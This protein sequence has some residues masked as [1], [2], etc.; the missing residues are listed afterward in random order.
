VSAALVVAW[1]AL[2]GAFAQTTV[3]DETVRALDG[4]HLI[5]NLSDAVASGHRLALDRLAT[6]GF[7]DQVDEMRS[8]GEF[9]QWSFSARAMLKSLYERAESVQSGEGDRFLAM[10]YRDAAR[11]SLAIAKDPVFAPLRQYPA[12]DLDP[13]RKPINFMPM[14][15]FINLNKHAPLSPLAE[16]AIS[17]VADVYAGPHIGRIRLFALRHLRNPQFSTTTFER[18][19][20]EAKGPR[21]AIRRMIQLGTPPPQPEKALL[22]ILKETASRTAILPS[23]VAQIMADLTEKLPPELE[24]YT[25]VEGDLES[26]KRQVVEAIVEDKRTRSDKKVLPS[27][28]HNTGGSDPMIPGGLSGGGGP[29]GGSLRGGAPGGS[30][31]LAKVYA[32]NYARYTG[33]TFMPRN[34]LYVT[35][36]GSTKPQSQSTDV[37]RTSRSFSKARFSA[38]A[39]RG[40]SVGATFDSKISGKP[41]AAYWIASEHDNR[42]GRLAVTIES[43]TGDSSVAVTRVMFAD[44]FYAALGVL[45]GQHDTEATF[46]DG[47]ILVL[48]SLDPDAD[49]PELKTLEKKAEVLSNRFEAHNTK[50]S[51]FQ[52]DVESFEVKRQEL[53]EYAEM[54]GLPEDWGEF[55][56]LDPKFQRMLMTVANESQRLERLNH[57]LEKSSL[58]LVREQFEL[59]TE[60]SVLPRGVVI[61]PSLFGRE[62]AW[63]AIR[64]DFSFNDLDLLREEA[65]LLNGNAQFPKQLQQLSVA[66]AL[67]WQFYER[68]AS[69]QLGDLLGSVRQLQVVSSGGTGQGSSRSHFAISLF[70][71]EETRLEKLEPKLQPLLDWLSINHHD[72]IR[73]GD[74]SESFSLLRWLKSEQTSITVIDPDGQSPAIPT[75]D[76]VV[77]GY[78]PELSSQ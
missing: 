4:T 34:P 49:V 23:E 29:A 36:T 18:A 24:H 46:Y 48:M 9:R 22:G 76:R 7:A 28:L 27:W 44:S 67:T 10:V 74:F 62:L 73:L 6:I 37:P 38:R 57:E 66:D 31:M 25:Q 63:S 17:A 78:G 1:I 14:S 53:I 50:A 77:I 33:E 35:T 47:E 60:G 59:F 72:Y 56:K 19:I 5:N 51:I 11:D 42:F 64:I 68:D 45:W 39:G 8:I 30:E 12:N 71:D 43:K 15:E 40:V 16:K 55:S 65:A 75:P 32:Q 2:Y 69:I 52:R 20:A 41:T 58:E 70:K 54:H 3:A 21:E 26:R 13:S 61:H